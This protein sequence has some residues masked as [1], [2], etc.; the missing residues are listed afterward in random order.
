M[1]FIN[2]TRNFIAGCVKGL[3]ISLS[4]K[5][6]D[7]KD[8]PTGS[9]WKLLRFKDPEDEHLTLVLERIMVPCEYEQAIYCRVTVL[10]EYRSSMI[11][12]W[13]RAEGEVHITFGSQGQLEWCDS[14]SKS[15]CDVMHLQDSLRFEGDSSLCIGSK[16]R[17]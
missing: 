14:E 1:N 17:V 11:T 13:E 10:K 7:S 3:W 4:A 16:Q 12:A 15:H 2:L 5:R 6:V 8:V 9:W